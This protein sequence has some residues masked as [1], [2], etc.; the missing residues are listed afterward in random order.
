MSTARQVIGDEITSYLLERK[1]IGRL[2]SIQR[3]ENLVDIWEYGKWCKKGAL[4]RLGIKPQIKFRGS[5][6][7]STAWD[8]IA[9]ISDDR[10]MEIHACT[11]GL[12]DH[13][14]EVIRRIYEDWEGVEDA[15]RSMAIGMERLDRYRLELLTHIAEKLFA[16]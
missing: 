7:E 6:P 10:G 2:S 4:H 8:G 12:E 14:L 9:D 1:D 11:I 3:L 5:R 15:R 16:D 13:H